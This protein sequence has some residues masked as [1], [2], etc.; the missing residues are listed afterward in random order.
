MDYNS[1][2]TGLE[3]IRHL[4][5]GGVEYWHAR[6]LLPLLD[7]TK[8]ANFRGV[9]DRACL[10]CQ[11]SGF[12]PGHHFAD[13]SK[14]V[15]IGSGAQRQAEDFYLTRYA[16][17]LIAMNSDPNKPEV[18]YAMTYFAVQ[19]RLQEVTEQLTDA[20]KRLQLRLRVMDNNKRLAGA[21]KKAGVVR[22][23]IFVDAGYRGLYGMGL[24]DVKTRKGL[25]PNED[26]L[27]NVGRLELSAHDFRS[28]LTEHRLNRDD[29]RTEQ[30]AIETHRAV[31]QQVRNVMMRDNGVRPEDLPKEPSI[32]RLV[33]KHRKQIK[34]PDSQQG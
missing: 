8:W 17:Y 20:E 24:S 14:M 10:A 22:Y 13:A 3:Q 16:C 23:P 34:G 2:V 27:D 1:Y 21:A 31:G 4:T 15:P 11:S 26:L 7:Y 19:T 28:T 5:P 12:S 9:I 32:K 6:E 25:L 30:R 33:Q 29:V 18:G